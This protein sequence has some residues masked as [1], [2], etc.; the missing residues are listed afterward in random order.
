MNKAIS[1]VRLVLASM[2]TVAWLLTAGEGP[3]GGSRHHRT[4]PSS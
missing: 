2:V 3:R 1:N 4:R